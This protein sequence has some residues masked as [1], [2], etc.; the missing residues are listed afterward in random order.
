M[1][2]WTMISRGK[3]WELSGCKEASQARTQLSSLKAGHGGVILNCLIR[4]KSTP[5]WS[6][7]VFSQLQTPWLPLITQGLP[8]RKDTALLLPISGK[9]P[10]TDWQTGGASS[11]KYMAVMGLPRRSW[12]KTSINGWRHRKC[13]PAD[14]VRLCPEAARLTQAHWLSYCNSLQSKRETRAC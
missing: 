2:I 12:W 6:W 11:C 13:C 1:G 8:H 5:P 14:K 4:Q 7:K 10:S 9:L 3:R